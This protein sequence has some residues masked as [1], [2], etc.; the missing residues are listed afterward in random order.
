M[1]EYSQPLQKLRALLDDIRRIMDSD[2]PPDDEEMVDIVRKYSEI[3]CQVNDCLIASDSLLRQGLRTEAIQRSER[4]EGLL[5]EL[6]PTLAILEKEGWLDFLQ[7]QGQRLPPPV[8]L[9]VAEGLQDAYLFEA[10]L[11]KLLNYHR[12]HALMRSPLSTRIKIL[13]QIA[14]R[15]QGNRIWNEDITKFERVRHRQLLKDCDA[16]VQ[17]TNLPALAALEEEVR[18]PDWL[19]TP[20]AKVANHVVNAHTRLRVDRSRKELRDLVNHLTEAHSAFDVDHGRELRSRWRALAAIALEDHDDPLMELAEPALKWLDQEDGRQEKEKAYEKALYKLRSLIENDAPY[21]QLRLA[22]N[23]LL[24]FDRGIEDALYRRLRDRYEDFHRKHRFRMVVASSAVFACIV[25]AALSIASMMS[26]HS[27]RRKWDGQLALV[28]QIVDGSPHKAKAKLLE[29]RDDFPGISKYRGYATMLEKVTQEVI[30]KE[31]IQQEIDNILKDVKNRV[32][33]ANLDDVSFF[34][35]EINRSIETARELAVQYS[36]LIAKIKGIDSD[37]RTAL[38][39]RKDSLAARF[40]SDYM[41]F[42]GSLRIDDSLIGGD[43]TDLEVLKYLRQ[44][45]RFFSEKSET[46]LLQTKAAIKSI[47]DDC[48][49]LCGFRPEQKRKKR[50]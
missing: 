22:E 36:D 12:L 11:E 2:S 29:L 26:R 7:L 1:P 27:D 14:R 4:A 45:D 21:E 10:S 49:S 28:D 35:K 46:E 34:Q 44:A 30:K 6:V 18:S 41:E 39:S 19:E 24:S 9:D 15:D 33:R 43:I 20:P 3:V 40:V 25:V 23:E 38:N 16:A 13:R 5:D 42:L 47:R 37:L 31:S 50:S 17:Q 8:L 48:T 32:N